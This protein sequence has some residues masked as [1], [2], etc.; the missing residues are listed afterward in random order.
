MLYTH[1]CIIDASGL[2]FSVATRT[3]LTW[4]FEEAVQLWINN[5]KTIV[6]SKLS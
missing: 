3:P 1:V 6:M 2:L 4:H 5:N